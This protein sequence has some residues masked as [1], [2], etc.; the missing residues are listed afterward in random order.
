M[1][2][3]LDTTEES[4]VAIA[5]LPAFRPKRFSPPL[6]QARWTIVM[7]VTIRT[8]ITIC[9]LP[10]TGQTSRK[11]TGLPQAAKHQT[12]K[13]L[14]FPLKVST[15]WPFKSHSTALPTT[16]HLFDPCHRVQPQNEHNDAYTSRDGQNLTSEVLDRWDVQLCP[17]FGLWTSRCLFGKTWFP[18]DQRGVSLVICN[19]HLCL[20]RLWEERQWRWLSWWNWYQKQNPKATKIHHTTL[21][22]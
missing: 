1:R 5:F 4:I 17:S 14:S 16:W 11:P 20:Q 6:V 8:W 3:P 2:L 13:A 19:T 18:F 12:L 10:A 9:T 15:Y 21:P 7:Q 22:Q